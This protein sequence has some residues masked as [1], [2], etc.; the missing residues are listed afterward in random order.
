VFVGST[1]TASFTVQDSLLDNGLTYAACSGATSEPCAAG[2]YACG[3]PINQTTACGIGYR[4]FTVVRTEVL[5]SNRAAYC[6]STCLIQDNYF[7]G[8]NLW[9]D[10]SNHAHASSVRNEQNNT[11]RHNSLACDYQ[12][13]N[14]E[15]KSPAGDLGCSADMSGYPDFAPI[16]NDTID[17]NLFIAN[18]G[19][20]AFHGGAGFC[21][22]GGST[23]GKSFSGDPTNGT[24]IKFTDN[25]FQRGSNGKCGSFGHVTDFNPLGTGNVWTGNKFDD[26]VTAVSG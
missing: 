2:T 19:A 3:S 8:T 1:P 26:G 6:E 22:Y 9:P 11:L 13:P 23:S 17:R 21:V 7:H 16:K 14:Y 10:Y 5:N 15:D 12:G 20:D 18:P 24:N 4:N 25:V